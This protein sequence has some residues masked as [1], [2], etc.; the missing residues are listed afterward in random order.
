MKLQGETSE[1]QIN[2]F[3]E[4]VLKW[5]TETCPLLH[6]FFVYLPPSLS[7]SS[8]VCNLINQEDNTKVS[9][10]QGGIPRPLK[11]VVVLRRLT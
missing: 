5:Q 9:I 4:S 6:R 1:A 2:M 7:L 11:A 3:D 10:N 8:M